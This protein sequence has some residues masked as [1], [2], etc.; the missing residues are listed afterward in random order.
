M[1]EGIDRRTALRAAAVGVAVVVAAFVVLALARGGG[2]SDADVDCETFRVTPA[3]WSS[4]SYDERRALM[5][6]IGFCGLIEG[7]SRLDV[8]A[9]VGAPDR[10]RPGE[11]GYDLPLGAGGSGDRQVWRIAFDDG[12][13][14]KSSTVDAPATVRTARP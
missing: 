14:V 13:R 6:G 10:E 2:S 8:Q 4:A 1:A 11:I 9:L 5:D 12:G 3:R 7:R